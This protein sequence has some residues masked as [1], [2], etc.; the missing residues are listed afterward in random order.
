MYHFY[1]NISSKI[2]MRNI[3]KFS[4]IEIKQNE[5]SLGPQIYA[6]Y[7]DLLL[8]ENE[9]K[10]KQSKR[11]DI[12]CLYITTACLLWSEIH[13]KYLH[14]LFDILCQKLYY[15]QH[16]KWH[17]LG[18]VSNMLIYIYIY[19]SNVGSFISQKYVE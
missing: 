10:A 2:H 8:K 19:I 14:V 6:L 1:L 3:C 5:T 15:H 16:V 12:V 7:G 9:T 11:Q 17:C 13:V 4:N 18:T